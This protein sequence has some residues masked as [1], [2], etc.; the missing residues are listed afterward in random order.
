MSKNPSIEE[1]LSVVESLYT[2]TET[3]LMSIDNDIRALKARVAKLE[4]QA[5]GKRKRK[6]RKGK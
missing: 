1:R 3:D 2:A 6:R 5:R 4:Q